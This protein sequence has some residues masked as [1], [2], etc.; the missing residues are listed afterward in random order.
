MQFQKLFFLSV[1]SIICA[2]LID[3]SLL[4]SYGKEPL[5]VMKKKQLEVLSYLNHQTEWVTAS[6]IA[7]AADCSVRSVKT[8]IAELNTSYPGLIASSRKGF[9]LSDREAAAR[10]Q[11]EA[12]NA[13]PQTQESRRAYMMQKLLIEN[14]RM[15]LDTLAGE[16]CISPLTLNNEIAR[17]KKEL[18]PFDLVFHTKN[19]QIW[20]DGNEKNKKKM[21]SHIIYDST[22]DFCCNMDAIQRFLPDIDLRIIREIVMVSLRE[23]HYYMDDFSLLNFTLHVGITTERCRGT[24][25]PLETET[26][27]ALRELTALPAHIGAIMAQIFQKL[28]QYF[29]VRLYASE[30]LDLSLLLMTRLIQDPQTEDLSALQEMIPPDIWKLL[31]LIQKKVRAT[32]YLNLNNQDFLFRLALHLKNM[33]VRLEN[34]ISLKN[35]QLHSIRNSYPFIYDVSVFIAGIIRQ[36]RGFLLSE[37]EIA[38]ITLHL[39]VQL[40]EQRV[41][42]DRVKLLLICPHYYSSNRKLLWKIQVLF[43]DS[44]LIRGALSGPEELPAYRDYD[45]IVSTMPVVP[46]PSVPVVSI[47]YQIGNSDI[48]AVSSAIEAVKKQRIKRILEQKLKYLFHENLFFYNPPFQSREEIISQ[49][50]DRLETAGYVEPNFKQKLF[51]RE[52]ISSSAFGSI[53]MPHP[54]EMCSKKTA[55]AVSCYPSSVPWNGNQVN[56]VL[57]LSIT[58]E[59][60]PLFRDIFDFVTEIL[61]DNRNFQALVS[62]KTYQEFI[63]LLVSLS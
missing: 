30:K 25:R 21:I 7:I 56:L 11:N 43:E 48:V 54:L 22:K 24:Q 28:E 62:T 1:F 32:F 53:A 19:N 49:M 59:D 61:S 26:Q 15:D 51:E 47:S 8:Y 45:L 35:P 42:R 2:I 39:G 33:F 5:D 37:D 10:L 17:F 29:H 12:G 63:Q 60:R 6:E 13:I 41:F 52:Q 46:A 34:Q 50:A 40:E 4:D 38:Y 9:R 58:E 18:I 16:L 36:E 27:D 23:H 57:M 55:I 3:K 44:I 20:I 14:Q 31:E